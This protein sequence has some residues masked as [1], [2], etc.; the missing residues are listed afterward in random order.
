ME[1]RECQQQQLSSLSTQDGREEK[2][3]MCWPG[4]LSRP[5]PRLSTE[6]GDLSLRQR[7]VRSI[8]RDICDIA[9]ILDMHLRG[10]SL[11]L[12][13]FRRQD[14]HIAFHVQRLSRCSRKDVWLPF[15]HFNTSKL[16]LVHLQLT[17][18][19][20]QTNNRSHHHNTAPI[21]HQECTVFLN[22]PLSALRY[23]TH[24]DPC[25]HRH[26]RTLTHSPHHTQ[27]L[28][29]RFIK[30]QCYPEWLTGWGTVQK[31]PPAGIHSHYHWEKASLVSAL[32][33]ARGGTTN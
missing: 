3:T 1:W 14:S 7:S 21:S 29:F 6:S 13:P 5:P 18:S 17:Y 16:C 23:C 2:V 11:S 4:I 33:T 26:R 28:V 27:C 32:V 30:P 24:L 8:T 19:V 12:K 25:T 9:C 15:L 22:I 31:S 10:V 20:K